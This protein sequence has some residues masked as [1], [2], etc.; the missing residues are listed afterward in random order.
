MPDKVTPSAPVEDTGYIN[1]TPDRWLKIGIGPLLLF[2]ALALPFLGDMEA[3]LGFGILFWMIYW[4]V[5]GVVD[6]KLTCFVPIIVV[7]FYPF[8]DRETVLKLYMHRDLFLI[9]GTALITASWVRWDLARR[10]SLKFLSVFSNDSRIQTIGW[11]WLCGI[12]SF[13]MGNTPVAAIFAPVAVAALFFAGYKTFKQ[14]Y[15]SKAASNVLIAVAWGASIGGMTTPLGG[16]QAVVTWGF[17]NDYIGTEVY[18]LDWTLRLLP[19]SLLCMLAVSIFIYYFMKPDPDELRFSGTKDFYRAELEKMGPMDRDEKI[20]GFGFLA[21][22]ILA[23]ARPLY[24]DYLTGPLFAWTAPAHLF[25]IFALL[26]FIIPSSREKGETLLTVPTVTKYFPVPILFIW[27][28]AIALGRVLGETGADVVFASWIEPLT[29]VAPSAAIFGISLASSFM[30]QFITDTAA[31]GILIPMFLEA[32]NDWF[33]LELGAVAMVWI[34]GAALNC[35]FAVVS[36]TGAQAVCA[37]FGANIRR[38]FIYGIQI[39][40]LTSLVVA[41]YF[42][43]TVGILELPFYLLP[44]R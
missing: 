4:W 24:A 14:R 23:L 21:I 34:A 44:P 9:A 1:A 32:F 36:S 22:I 28:A 39:A 29:Q 10:I 20:L 18:F 19:V 38:M 26:L 42:V 15:D 43:V 31:A 16:G 37:G 35:S 30:S 12:V 2:I 40:I 5:S 3:R 11:F 6:M 41:I 25:F 7:A 27:P 13:V 17:L 8:V 33:G